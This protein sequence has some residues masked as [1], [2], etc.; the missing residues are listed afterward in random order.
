MA[1][2]AGEEREDK[3]TLSTQI[4]EIKQTLKAIH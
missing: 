1:S 2:K 4:E 3:D